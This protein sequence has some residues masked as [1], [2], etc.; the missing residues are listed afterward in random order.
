MSFAGTEIHVHSAG[1][2]TRSAIVPIWLKIDQII[3]L[4]QSRTME[5]PD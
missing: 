3:V 1:F 2:L 5:A 4:K